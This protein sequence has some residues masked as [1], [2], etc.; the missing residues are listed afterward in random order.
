[1][2][3]KQYI[4][5]PI[6]AN[7][8][9]LVDEETKDGVL[10]DCSEMKQEILDDVK[11]LGANVKYILLTHGHFDHVLGVNEM[12]KALGA[13]VYINKGDVFMLDNIKQIMA[14]FGMTQDVEVPEYDELIE[15]GQELPFGNTKIKT[16][17]TS[18][19]SEGGVCYLIDDKLFSGDTLFRESVGRT[20]LYGGNFKTLLNSIKGTLFNLDD[21]IKVYPGH[22]PSSTIGHEKNYN[23]FM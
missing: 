9:L 17:Y 15:D 11:T 20:D 14:M 19:H 3:L 7:N 1:M 4:A 22:G 23:Q 6:E 5:G 2:I 13:K 8:Y 12:K 10:I 16:I 18:G 21:D